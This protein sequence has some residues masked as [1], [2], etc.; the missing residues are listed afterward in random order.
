MTVHSGRRV[1]SG[2]TQ[3]ASRRQ[4]PC[5]DC[6]ALTR[7]VRCPACTRAGYRVTDA[8]RGSAAARDYGPAWRTLSVAVLERD[9]RVCHWCGD[10]ATTADHVI[11]RR[12]GGTDD[13]GNL[14]AACRRCNSGRTP[15]RHR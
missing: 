12:A 1:P 5:I 11:P 3:S 7:A 15:G 14:V 6:G 2:H 13:L 8:L 10:T 9:G 4:R